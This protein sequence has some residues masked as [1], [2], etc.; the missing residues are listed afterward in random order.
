MARRR[1]TI[2]KDRATLNREDA[3]RDAKRDAPR[4][5][6]SGL[7]PSIEAQREQRECVSAEDLWLTCRK[8]SRVALRG[9][10][11]SPDDRED[12]AAKLVADVLASAAEAVEP[13]R[14]GATGSPAEVLAYIDY[15]LRLW[16]SSEAGLLPRR[17]SRLVFLPRLIDS[18]KHYRESIDRVRTRDRMQAED[19]AAQEATT[20]AALGIT[21][22]PAKHARI[23]GRSGALEARQAAVT[24]CRDL[25]LDQVSSGRSWRPATDA[26]LADTGV[27]RVF[28]QWSRERSGE[29]CAAECG[30]SYGTWRT[31]VHRGAEFVQRFYSAA[32]LARKLTLGATDR[33]TVGSVGVED[34]RVVVGRTGEVHA[35]PMDYG[36][37][38]TRL[39]E[40]LR[41]V[42]DDRSREA[43]THTPL[44]AS[45]PTAEHW[46]EP[47]YDRP[48]DRDAARALC[49]CRRVNVRPKRERERA[50]GDTLQHEADSLQTLARLYAKSQRRERTAARRSALAA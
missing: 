30:I 19:R 26:E 28:Y 48:A 16:P 37:V 32:E 43:H 9:T 8:A 40:Y 22:T 31:S 20:P 15:T 33:E 24:M 2:A 35:Y 4:R 46:R 12:C 1:T 13:R 34:Y 25:R 36:S 18:A 29:V 7:L 5:S 3:K 21:E 23:V 41:I 6:P 49:D 47:H 50:K 39:A 38:E 10:M 14:R 45:V 17:D 42:T 44:L 27:W 11:Y